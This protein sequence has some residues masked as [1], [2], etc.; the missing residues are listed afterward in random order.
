MI[1]YFKIIKFFYFVFIKFIQT[2]INV[3]FFTKKLTF[4]LLIFILL[5]KLKLNYF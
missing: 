2:K 5:K 3:N 1:N 4:E